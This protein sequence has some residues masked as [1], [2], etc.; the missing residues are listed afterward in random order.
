[1]FWLIILLI[2]VLGFYLYIYSNNWK[3]KYPSFYS[4]ETLITIGHRG[5]PLI[6]DENTI[7]SFMKAIASGLKGVEL[8]VQYSYDKQLIVYHDWLMKDK[9]GNI[10]LV[11]DM[12]YVIIVIEIKSTSFFNTRIEEKILDI[13]QN[14]SI[15]NSCIISSFNPFILRRI[16]KLNP[17][18][19]TAYLWTKKDSQLIINSPLWVWLCRPDGFHAD[20]VFLEDKLMD[21]IRRKK[22][23]AVAYT[24]KSEKDLIKAIDLKLDGIIMNDPCLAINVNKSP[25]QNQLL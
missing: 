3:P 20:I 4:K 13:I 5:A 14:Y 23:T 19:L 6:T 15:E 12:Y 9:D 11:K 21:W 1:M 10:R 24:I 22:M 17:N 16:R 25:L 7:D 8:D 18:I 2:I